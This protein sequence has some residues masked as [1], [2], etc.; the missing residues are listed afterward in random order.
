MTEKKVLIA[1]GSWFGSTE[2][3]S[4]EIGSTAVTDNVKNDFKDWDQIREFT[5]KFYYL[6]QHI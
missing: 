1:F 4:K 3:I 5:K 6:V 2:E